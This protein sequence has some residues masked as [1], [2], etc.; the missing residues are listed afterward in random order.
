MKFTNKML[1]SAV[2]SVAAMG[3]SKPVQAELVLTITGTPGSSTISYEATG[4]YVLSADIDA[5][6]D[7]T[8]ARLPADNGGGGGLIWGG[9]F[10]NDLGPGSFFDEDAGI[11]QEN[12]GIDI[13]V[14]TDTGSGAEFLTTFG[15]IDTTRASSDDGSDDFRIGLGASPNVDYPA[16]AAGDEVSWSGSGN[17]LLASNFEDLF[18]GTGTFSRESFSETPFSLVVVS[19]V[20]EPS[21][22]AVLGLCTLA[23][24]PMR[25]NRKQQ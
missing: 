21:S 12:F 23:L 25:R 7:N 2:L 11:A 18:D 4:T 10:D 8:A 20:P 14:F 16:L 24:L 17:I 9:S 6:P 22:F 3:V 13:D 1:T 5:N 15:E 19:A